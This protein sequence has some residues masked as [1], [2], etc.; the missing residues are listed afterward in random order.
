MKYEERIHIVRDAITSFLARYSPPKS[1]TEESMAAN[2]TG[3]CEAINKRISA[4]LNKDQ[5]NTRI[6]QILDAVAD[7]HET[8]A[9]PIQSEFVKAIERTSK[10]AEPS[11]HP[12]TNTQQH[13]LTINANRIKQ[14]LPVSDSYLWGRLAHE[15]LKATDITQDQINS[16]RN[17]HHQNLTAIYGPE[18]TQHILEDLSQ[19]HQD[20][21]PKLNPATQ[22]QPDLASKLDHLAW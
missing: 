10:A 20:A 13:D 15:L 4:N 6:A 18:K 5:F 17:A 2:F 3:I 8:N 12:E 21:N 1:A 19:R 7:K 14:G 16:Y 9:W 11:R 22:W